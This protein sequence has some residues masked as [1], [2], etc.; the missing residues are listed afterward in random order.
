MEEILFGSEK[1]TI[2]VA[3]RIIKTKT[4]NSEE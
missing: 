3:R 2:N 1:Q 4:G